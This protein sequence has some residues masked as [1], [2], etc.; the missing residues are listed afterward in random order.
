MTYYVAQIHKNYKKN[1][2]LLLTYFFST[3]ITTFFCGD[4]C[5]QDMKLLITDLGIYR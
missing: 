1:S 5:I 3:I 2:I 4:S